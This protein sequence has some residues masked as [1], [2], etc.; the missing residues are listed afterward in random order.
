MLDADRGLV[1]DAP[2]VR[3]ERMTPPAGPK[4]GPMALVKSPLSTSNTAEISGLPEKAIWNNLCQ[5]PSR[6]AIRMWEG[7]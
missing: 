2:A 5:R 4:R 1:V 3:F 6:K 7:N